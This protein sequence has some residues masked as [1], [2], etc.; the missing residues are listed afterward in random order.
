MSIPNAQT[1]HHRRRVTRNWY[2]LKEEPHR[3]ILGVGRVKLFLPAL[4]NLQS[5]L[6]FN[7][8]KFAIQSETIT[9]SP[10]RNNMMREKLL[11]SLNRS[12]G[13]RNFDLVISVQFSLV[14]LETIHIPH[15]TASKEVDTRNFGLVISVQFSLVYLETLHILH[16]TASKKV[17]T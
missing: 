8:L 17:G 15:S 9:S 11:W 1:T 2:S 7:T 10:V 4:C 6:R 14:Y 5:F 12:K 3:R 13:P 16:S